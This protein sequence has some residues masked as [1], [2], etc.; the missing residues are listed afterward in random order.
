ML[1][2][3]TDE[4]DN[5]PGFMKKKC[6]RACDSCGWVDAGCE[7]RPHPAP[8]KHEGGIS[9]V[10]ERAQHLSS[11]GPTVRSR[12]PD[13]PWIITFDNFVSDAEADAFLSTTDHHFSRSLA[14]DMVSP[15]RTSQQAWCQAGPCETDPLVNRVHERVVNVTGVPKNN[16]EFFQVLRYEEGQFYKTHHD[17][18]THPDSLSGVRLFTFFIYLRTPDGGGYTRFPGLNIRRAAAATPQPTPSRERHPARAQRAA[19]Q[20][21]RAALAERDGRR[22]AQVGHAHA[23]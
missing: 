19:A 1:G 5:N 13:G 22:P 8:A 12:P 3:D 15:V 17:Q 6:A 18:N 16:A 4:C 9:A 10:F 7:E 20:G 11:L 23:A 21:L 2:N 14:G